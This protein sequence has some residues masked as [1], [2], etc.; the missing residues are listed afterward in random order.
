MSRDAIVTSSKRFLVSKNLVLV[1][2]GVLQVRDDPV[3]MLLPYN[4]TG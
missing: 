2:C 3:G 4:S 1:G